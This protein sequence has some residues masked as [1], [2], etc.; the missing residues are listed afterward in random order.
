MSR[1]ETRRRVV[2]VTGVSAIAFA[3]AL[4]LALGAGC[5]FDEG[6]YQ[7]GGRRTGAPT[8]TEEAPLP[9]PTSTT[10]ASGD[11][12][13][14]SSASSDANIPPQDTGTGG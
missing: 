10:S 5:I 14:S 11:G 8:S 1:V 6:S 7:G 9:R 12:S 3:A 4:A 13:S 2:F